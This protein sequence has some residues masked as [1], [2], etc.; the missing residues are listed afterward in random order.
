MNFSSL[1][2]LLYP[3]HQY[4]PEV[5]LKIM[6]LNMKYASGFAEEDENFLQPRDEIE[7]YQNLESII[8]LIESH[9]IDIL[10]LQEVDFD[11]TRTG[12]INQAE[13]ITKALGWTNLA[14][15]VNIKFDETPFL[16]HVLW[17]LSRAFLVSDLGG[18]IFG[19]AIG[20]SD[21]SFPQDP[22]QINFGQAVLSKYPIKNQRNVYYTKWEEKGEW[23]KHYDLFTLKDERKSYFEVE[24][25]YLPNHPNLKKKNSLFVINTHLD[26]RNP[27][28]R[29]TQ[30]EKILKLLKEKYDL[31][32]QVH[33][34]VAGDFNA[35]PLGSKIDIEDK[36][37]DSGMERL[38]RSKLIKYYPDIYPDNYLLDE[39]ENPI[40]PNHLTTYSSEN[41]RTI[42][43]AILISPSLD[44]LSY[45]VDPT[46]VSDHLAVV[47]KIR[48]PR[49]IIIPGRLDVLNKMIKTY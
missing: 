1:G 31:N 14:Q 22:V 12:R 44:Y 21:L 40:I 17:R 6:S 29:R 24:I 15:T 23:G 5:T 42:I 48:I 7:I 2:D 45:E 20:V 3:R 8:E 43:D 46:L 4:V 34:L 41:R 10:C 11:S 18:K 26:C 25:D 19:G 35:P 32:Q 33:Y 38:L 28:L 13:Y 37:T 27:I 9:D 39:N 49:D 47:A 36:H 30:P 16:N